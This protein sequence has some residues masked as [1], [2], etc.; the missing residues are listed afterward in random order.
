MGAR[1]FT[2]VDLQQRRTERAHQEAKYHMTPLEQAEM[3][4]FDLVEDVPVH[5]SKIG[6]D[7]L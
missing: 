2:T 1:G 5:C 7:D 3:V 6:L 4:S